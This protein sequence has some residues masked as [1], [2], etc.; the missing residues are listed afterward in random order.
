MQAAD[1]SS[2]SNWNGPL[3][4]LGLMEMGAAADRRP[5]GGDGARARGARRWPHEFSSSL[6]LFLSLTLAV[7]LSWFAVRKFSFDFDAQFFTDAGGCHLT[8]FGSV[9]FFIDVV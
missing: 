5:P 3:V 9:T 1:V 7:I 2:G 4:A 8:L 6:V